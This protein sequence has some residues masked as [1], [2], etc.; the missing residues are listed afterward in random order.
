MS[1][2]WCTSCNQ[3][4]GEPGFC[5]FDG[6]PLTLPAPGTTPAPGT[7]P[8]TL[9]ALSASDGSSA[10]ALA[11]F[12]TGAR[13]EY[14]HL[15]GQTLDGRY[16]IERKIGEGG[17][18]VVFAARHTV[19]EKPLAVKVLKRD[20]AR[21]AATVKRFVQ[22]AKAASRIG[23]P[24]IVDVTDF[25]TTPDGMTYS[26]MEYVDG[27]TL[28]SAI[29]RSAPFPLTR[30]VPIAAQI[31]RALGAAHDKGI[32]HRD[33]KPENV[34]LIN[35]DGRRDFVK[36][37]DFG[38]AKVTPLEGQPTDGP[39][40]T[41]AGSV[42]GTPEY[43]APEQAAGRSDTDNR[44]DIYA[45]ATILYELVTGRVPHKSDSMVRTLAM[46]MLDPIEPPSKLRPDLEVPIEF[47]R[48]LMKGLAKKRDQR[49]ASMADFL[50]DLER[51]C[52]DI[53]TTT[54]GPSDQLHL[55]AAPPGADM[56]L[57]SSLRTID[58][59]PAVAGPEVPTRR[60]HA[61]SNAPA[62]AAATAEVRGEAPRATS[63]KVANEPA[64]VTS[65]RQVTFEHVFDPTDEAPRRRARWPLLVG[66]VL[67]AGGGGVA[68][69]L[70]MR[71]EEPATAALEVDAAVADATVPLIVDGGQ[72][73]PGDAEVIAEVPDDAGLL[74]DAGR[75]V[76]HDAGPPERRI[77]AGI[78][79]PRERLTAR[80]E[81]TVQV[82]TYPDGGTI[83][84]GDSYRG[85][86]G[87]TIEEPPGTRLKIKCTMAGHE[88]GFVDLVF[89]ASLPEVV[90]CRP[91]RPKRCIEGLHNPFDDCPDPA[92]P[93]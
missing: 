42:F 63:R 34:F 68:I 41:R 55:V 12:G 40:L 89:D 45:L 53:N 29:K 10:A 64:F 67:L 28:S 14:G 21:D 86:S 66:A 91:T 19:I 59:V 78:R 54:P 16:Y 93:K 70:M 80:G 69:A 17:M 23:H 25:G 38:I 72:P 31:A 24:S 6:T 57:M 71:A 52:P 56:A 15:I 79:I 49:Y 43:M 46:Q 50:T 60:A 1:K 39:R 82:I 58:D 85:P 5:P 4:Y 33:L 48:V 36:I 51:A 27:S 44:V 75:R 9:R 88:P 47:E 8:E 26:V 37:V 35:R 73:A 22:E 62:N 3:F 90:S 77:D 74:R 76:S 2:Y 30:A 7:Q 61:P 84:A 13:E 20:V 65:Q 81:L 92:P 11:A 87:T 32:V 83:Y 18:G